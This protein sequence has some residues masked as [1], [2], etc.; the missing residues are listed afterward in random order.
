[1][2]HQKSHQSQGGQPHLL[3]GS[4]GTLH[5]G[6]LFAVDTTY[7]VLADIHVT[8]GPAI[9]FQFRQGSGETF[10]RQLLTI[11]IGRSPA[12]SDRSA[13]AAAVSMGF[14]WARFDKPPPQS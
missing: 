10:F 5:L 8:G 11:E 2:W 3:K 7:Y 13:N 14:G 1:M 4:D 12:A 6:S 9:G